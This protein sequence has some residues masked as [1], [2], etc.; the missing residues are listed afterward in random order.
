MLQLNL[1]DAI[2]EG[3]GARV[4]RCW[5]FTMP[6][7]HKD[8]ASSRKYALECLYLIFQYYALLSPKDAHSLIWNR[9][10]KAKTGLGGNILLDMA[11]GHFNLFIKTI[12]RKLGA[13][14]NNKS[15]INR[16]V[17]A[18]TANKSIMDNFDTVCGIV[19]RSGKH[20]ERSTAK[21]MIKLV[22]ELVAQDALEYTPGR[23]YQLFSEFKRTMLEDLSVHS[24]YTWINEHKNK[25]SKQ[26]A[27]R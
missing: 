1:H 9:F 20:T 7:L 12:L 24:F 11:L 5:K 14:M 17:K 19:E 26:I 27:A 25:L 21:D 23:S 4:L 16:L 6:Y 22:D 13:N 18:L 10:H 2:S 15:A 8:G 3:D